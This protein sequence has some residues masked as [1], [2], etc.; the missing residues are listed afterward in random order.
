MGLAAQEAAAPSP[1]LCVLIASL[2]SPGRAAWQEGRKAAGEQTPEGPWVSPREAV[3][4]GGRAL[5]V[6]TSRCGKIFHAIHAPNL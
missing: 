3:S 4:V 5:R 6:A 1:Q 2:G